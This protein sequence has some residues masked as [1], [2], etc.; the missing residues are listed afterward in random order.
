MHDTDAEPS[1][2][3][4]AAERA[5]LPASCIVILH[6][7]PHPATGV[8]ISEAGLGC[9]I[10]PPLGSGAIPLGLMVKVQLRLDSEEALVL[11]AEIV[12]AELYSGGE[13]MLGLHVRYVSESAG[14]QIRTFIAAHRHALAQAAG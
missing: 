9:L 1:T 11:T 7:R 5:T 6:G 2:E 10:N 8:D 3:R 12:R 4:R 14:G 13:V